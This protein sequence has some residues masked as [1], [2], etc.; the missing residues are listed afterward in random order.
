MPLTETGQKIMANMKKQY[1]ER[2][3]EVFYRSLNAGQIPASA[4]TD[5]HDA[6]PDEADC[7]SPAED[8][9]SPPPVLGDQTVVQTREVEDQGEASNIG[10]EPPP[11]P[12]PD[13][14]HPQMHPNAST[15]PEKATGDHGWGMRDA[16]VGYGGV[17]GGA[18]PQDWGDA[19]RRLE[20]ALPSSVSLNDI[21]KGSEAHWPQWKGTE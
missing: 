15:P 21:L 1:G 13:F 4:H 11:L 3:E 8:Q 5:G 18:I 2:G 20:D 19:G 16:S 10:R 12:K 17:T 14:E 9:G 7:D 6:V